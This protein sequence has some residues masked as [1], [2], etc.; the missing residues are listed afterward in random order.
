MEKANRKKM[1][2]PPFSFSGTG[3]PVISP[4]VY[5]PADPTISARD[6]GLVF[7]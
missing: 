5:E 2:S 6:F 7:R 3:I 1:A 4:G